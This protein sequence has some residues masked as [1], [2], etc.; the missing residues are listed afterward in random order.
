M[1]AAPNLDN[2]TK[3]A[4]FRHPFFIPVFGE[5]NV[6]VWEIIFGTVIFFLTFLISIT[7]VPTGMYVI[8]W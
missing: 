6:F 3:D 2:V 7:K 1:K 5:I 8:M 4:Y